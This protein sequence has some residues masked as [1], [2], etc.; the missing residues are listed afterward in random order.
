MI[1]GAVDTSGF[2]AVVRQYAQV[3]NKTLEAAFWRQI[4]SWAIKAYKYYKSRYPAATSK[5]KIMALFPVGKGADWQWRFVESLMQKDGHKGKITKK[6][7]RAFAKN[8]KD[9]RK[10]STGFGA[11]L[12]LALK[13]AAENKTS[14]RINTGIKGNATHK[15]GIITRDIEV[16]ASARYD[17]KSPQSRAR[18]PRKVE[19]LE[20]KLNG[21]FA[22]TLNAQILDMEWYI[23][24]KLQE[25]AR[26]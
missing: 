5:A 7:R 2:D 15:G 16:G 13:A 10:K 11:L 26:A 12:I 19:K 23:A 9:N 21:A 8:E 3:T 14:V 18:I 17:F 20:S 22:A 1:G 4:K 6:A 24:T 25:A